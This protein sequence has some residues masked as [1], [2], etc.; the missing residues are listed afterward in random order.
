MKKFVL[1]LLIIIIL[2]F[3]GNN[4]IQAGKQSCKDKCT[5]CLIPEEHNSVPD[6][7]FPYYRFI[8]I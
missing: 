8:N 1:S 6:E 4:S 2:S 5:S 3:S 7:F